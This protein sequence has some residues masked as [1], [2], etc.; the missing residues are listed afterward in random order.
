MGILVTFAPI[1]NIKNKT[2]M[3]KLITLFAV[4]ATVMMWTACGGSDKPDDLPVSQAATATKS[5]NIIAAAGN[6]A[7]AEIVFQLSD[8]AALSK[9]SKWVKSG[10]VQT[11]SSI[12]VSQLAE[13]QNIKLTEVRLYMAS[14]SK[15]NISLQDI[16]NSITFKDL[17]Q[18]NFLQN[19]INEVVSKG[20]STL[21]LHYKTSAD[22]TSPVKFEIKLDG[23]FAF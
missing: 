21:K 9:Y 17:P 10:L 8:F 16:T 5:T 7:E 13:S 3:K 11:T 23:N 22:I 6:T 2:I 19:V 20:S 15:I 4:F 18:L 14:N 12:S 1:M